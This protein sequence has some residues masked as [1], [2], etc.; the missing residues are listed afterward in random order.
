MPQLTQVVR[1]HNDESRYVVGLTSV[2]SRCLFVL[3]DP[4]EQHIEV[5]ETMTFKLQQ[6][7]NVTGLTDD[8]SNDLTSCVVNSCLYVSDYTNATVHKIELTGDNEVFKWRL[9]DDSMPNGLSINTECNLLVSCYDKLLEYTSNGSLVRE[10]RL[11]S[12]RLE[13][14]TRPQHA[15]KRPCHAIQLTSD[16]FVVSA[17]DDTDVL[18]FGFSRMRSSKSHDVIEV[19]SRGQVVFSYENQLQSTTRPEFKGPSHLA[20]DK[21]NECIF[22]AD[23]G[24]DRI[25]MLKRSLKCAREFKASV[26]GSRLQSPSRVYFNQSNSH[27]YVGEWI[28]GGRIFVF[29]ISSFLTSLL[30]NL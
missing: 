16:Q 12:I 5:Y 24:N 27:L 19:N 23:V 13:S 18:G 4:S 14:I 17:D 2:D 22:V 28:N 15:M 25:V 10:I 30:M 11:E 1:L 6:T 26:D 21:N 29:D 8:A 7:L 9:A 20:V 3:R